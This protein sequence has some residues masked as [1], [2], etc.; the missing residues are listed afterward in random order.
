VQCN[1]WHLITGE[2]PPQ[3]GGVSDYSRL[4]AR[5]LATTG[6]QVHVWAPPCDTPS[7][8]DPTVVVHRL[9]DHFGLRSLR[10]LDSALKTAPTS[11]RILV[12]YVP[13]AFGWRAMN[14]PFC[15]WLRRRRQPVWVMFHEVAYPWEKGQSWRHR[16]L[17]I[18]TARMAGWVAGAAEQNF[19]SIPQWGDLLRQRCGVNRDAKWLP[20]PSNVATEVSL[21]A[22]GQGRARL[23]IASTTPLIGHFGTY[24]DLIV[25]MLLEMLPPLLERHP[26]WAVLL[27]GRGSETLLARLQVAY[28]EHRKRIF[29]TGALSAQAAAQSLAACDVMLQPFPDGISCRRG[30]A[31]AALA[32]GLPVVTTHGHLTESLWEE[33]QAVRLARVGDGAGMMALIE[34]LLA[35]TPCRMELRARAAHLYTQLFSLQRTIAS[36]RGEKF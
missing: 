34:E 28:P 24:G 21:V 35:D 33:T 8:A 36:L 3:W 13:H 15:L 17:A 2:Y 29:G 9:P 22:A 7:P 11:A 20:V 12:Q 4:I 5:E 26:D 18:V 25:A 27:I 23:G 32:L 6:D 19:V 16:L 14:V 30:S 1:A 31:M 10:I